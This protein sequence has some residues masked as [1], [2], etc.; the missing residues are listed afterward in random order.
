MVAS[1]GSP[2]G[3]A[4][5]ATAVHAW[6]STDTGDEILDVFGAATRQELDDDAHAIA[7]LGE[8]SDVVADLQANPVPESIE[9]VSIAARG[10][11]VVPAGRTA[12]PGA[13][14]ATVSVVGVDAHDH[15][16]DAPEATHQILLALAGRPPVCRSLAD[17]LVDVAVSDGIGFLEDSLGATA[18]G[19]GILAPG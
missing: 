17:T 13:R 2:H 1:L 11:V 8:T 19:A 9:A 16:P 14:R 4:D 15:L 3:G 7:Q 18:A 5:L 10:D 6:T 12:A